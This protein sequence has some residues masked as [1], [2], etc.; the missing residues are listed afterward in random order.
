M[1]AKQT[2]MKPEGET[3]GILQRI[4]VLPLAGLF[5]FKPQKADITFVAG[6]KRKQVFT[7]RFGA[8]CIKTNCQNPPP[9]C[10]FSRKALLCCLGNQR[11]RPVLMTG[12][13][14]I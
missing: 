13:P 9:C 2:V 12:T 7:T 10:L 8:L 6:E 14:G 3:L 1:D 4:Y 5:F 11:T